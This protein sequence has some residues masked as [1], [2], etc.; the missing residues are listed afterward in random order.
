MNENLDAY[1]IQCQLDVIPDTYIIQEYRKRMLNKPLNGFI[2]IDDGKASFGITKL[3]WPNGKFQVE[4]HFKRE[5]IDET[6]D[7]KDK[8]DNG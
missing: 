6:N 2:E 3:N 1:Q 8:K 5:I 7:P 4:I